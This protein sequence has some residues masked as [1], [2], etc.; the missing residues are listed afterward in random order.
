MCA[1]P[2][3]RASRRTHALAADDA[4]TLL[5]LGY[6]YAHAGRNADARGLLERA[7][8]LDPLTPLTHGVQG[9]VPVLEGRFA[10]AVEP[11][12]R[13]L[14]MDPE[15]PFA[16]VFLGWAL[17]YDRRFEEAT[18]ALDDAA[19]RFPGT[20]FGSFARSLAHGLRGEAE[21]A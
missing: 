21:A 6:I 5:L 12:R 8:E 9:F 13:N 2:C 14:E 16:A 19:V 1:P 20:A 11:Y 3:G 10:D 17:A 15:S 7:L 4:D 18:A